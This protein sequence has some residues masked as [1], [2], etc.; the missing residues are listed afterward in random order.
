MLFRSQITKL[1]QQYIEKG[2][3]SILS[4]LQ[5]KDYKVIAEYLVAD[6]DKDKANELIGVY[7]KDDNSSNF[8]IEIYK[9]DDKKTTYLTKYNKEFNAAKIIALYSNDIYKNGKADVILVSTTT[10]N[11]ENLAIFSSENGNFIEKLNTTADYVADINKDGILE[12][13]T[14]I[15]NPNDSTKKAT[16]W[17][18]WDGKNVFKSATK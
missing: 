4:K 3:K 18:T 14:I 5:P 17:K 9:E 13:G 12:L 8:K 6:V 7:K 10:D 11:K 16:S 15:Q 1:E 2:I